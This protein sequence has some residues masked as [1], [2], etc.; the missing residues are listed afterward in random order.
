M[1]YLLW[2]KP[3]QDTE[4]TVLLLTVDVKHNYA[5]FAIW[6]WLQTISQPQAIWIGKKKLLSN[7]RL[8][9]ELL[10]ILA[11]ADLYSHLDIDM[12]SF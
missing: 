8:V 4:N 2:I 7:W 6:K 12:S 1:D 9:V 10:H 11:N 5:V 3:L